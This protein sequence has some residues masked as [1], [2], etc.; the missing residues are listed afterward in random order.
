MWSAHQ[1]SEYFVPL[2]ILQYALNVASIEKLFSLVPSIFITVETNLVYPLRFR[3][4]NI[5]AILGLIDKI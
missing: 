4:D 5:Q 3:L 1:T 2:Q